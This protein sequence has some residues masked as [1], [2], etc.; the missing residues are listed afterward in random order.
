MADMN[1]VPTDSGERRLPGRAIME[2]SAFDH[3]PSAEELAELRL[4][5]DNPARVAVLQQMAYDSIRDLNRTTQPQD[6]ANFAK[7][8]ADYL[9]E[10]Q[11]EY[12]LKPDDTAVAGLR[13]TFLDRERGIK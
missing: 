2:V 5:Q 3:L 6:F 9:Q 12:D 8:I 11:T 13:R 10:L 1:G 4:D 7:A